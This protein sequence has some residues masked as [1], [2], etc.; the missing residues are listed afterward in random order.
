MIINHDIW[1]LK[2]VKDTITILEIIYEIWQLTIMQELLE[3]YPTDSANESGIT[4]IV[5]KSVQIFN[6]SSIYSKLSRFSSIMLWNPAI[7][8]RSDDSWTYQ[9][10]DL[11]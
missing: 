11:G 8:E 4:N 6:I 5:D 1:Q 7:K 3:K 9:M 10:K 2:K